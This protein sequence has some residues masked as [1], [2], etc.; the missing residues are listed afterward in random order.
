MGSTAAETEA[1]LIEAVLKDV[2]PDDKH[3]QECIQSEAPRQK[4]TL[5]QPV[6]L[7]LNEVTQ[8]EDEKM[9]G[10]NPS[11]FAPLGAGKE[12]VAWLE[13]ID[14]PVEWLSWND[15]AEFCLKLS[16]QE[17]LKPFYFREGGTI[18][19]LDGTGYRLP[20]EAEWEFACRA[21]L[22]QSTGLATGTKTWCGQGG[23]A[24]TPVT[25]RMRRAS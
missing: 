1:V 7:G 9:M 11:H 21:G 19:S 17:K 18:T 23:S 25:A 13:T 6:Y 8:A 14:H 12:A 5:T 24:E 15:A 3:T 22:Q 2:V 16:K 4:V 10:V 20:S